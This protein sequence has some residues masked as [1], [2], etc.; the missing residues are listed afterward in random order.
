MHMIHSWYIIEILS[1]YIY[2]LN[3]MNIIFEIYLMNIYLTYIQI[4]HLNELPLF[5]DI[6]RPQCTGHLGWSSSGGA[7]RVATAPWAAPWPGG[8]PLGPGTSR[9]IPGMELACLWW[10]FKSLLHPLF[11]F[12]KWTFCCSWSFSL[13]KNS[14]ILEDHPI[15][16]QFAVRWRNQPL[17][18]TLGYDGLTWVLTAEPKLS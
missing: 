12:L 5:I 8:S 9:D 18:S 15:H 16:P 2:I 7:D 13:T 14:Y 6:S 3:N 11:Q 17:G 4:E 10:F 1:I